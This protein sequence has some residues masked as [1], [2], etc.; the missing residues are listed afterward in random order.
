MRLLTLTSE[1]AVGEW[2]TFSKT[3]DGK[4]AIEFRVRRVPGA[5]EREIEYGILGYKAALRH[6]RGEA[7]QDLDMQKLDRVNRAKAAYCLVDS[8]GC[9]IDLANESDVE[10]FSRELKSPVQLGALVNLDGRWTDGL[11]DRVLEELGPLVTWLGRR[12]KDLDAAETEDE[13]GKG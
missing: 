1:T 8:R 11:R 5:K 7:L 10:L 3:Q 6:R 9:E 13:E 2:F 12:V 4:P